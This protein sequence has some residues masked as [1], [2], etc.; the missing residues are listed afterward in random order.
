MI[1]T[2]LEFNV[3]KLLIVAGI[4]ALSG[5]GIGAGFYSGKEQ[6]STSGSYRYK[7]TTIAATDTQD[8]I[9][10]KIGDPARIEQRGSEEHWVYNRELAFSGPVIQ[11]LI[12]LP[13]VFPVGYRHTTLV[14]ENQKLVR[15]VAENA[16]Y[17]GF[18]CGLQDEAGHVGCGPRQAL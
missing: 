9:R 12:P 18:L 6:T 16:E 1:C 15:V 5:C 11:V 17:D 8:A 13:L 2:L 4:M 7:N 14:F 3:K 10:T